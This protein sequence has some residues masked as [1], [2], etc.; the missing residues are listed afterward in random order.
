MFCAL[1]IIS[2]LRQG[3]K[4][5]CDQ[6]REK[7]KIKLYFHITPTNFPQSHSDEVGEVEWWWWIIILKAACQD[8]EPRVQCVTTVSPPV[9]AFI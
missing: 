5:N 9:E 1:Q 6:K 3:I 4:Q 7:K 8:R 2:Q